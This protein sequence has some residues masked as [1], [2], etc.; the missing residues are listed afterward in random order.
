MGQP[1]SGIVQ[2]NLAGPQMMQSG[3][4]IHNGYSKNYFVEGLGC[5]ERYLDIEDVIGAVIKF[6]PIENK[7]MAGGKISKLVNLEL[8]DLENN[9]LPVSR[10]DQYAEQFDTFLN[11]NQDDR[12]IVIILQFGKFKPF[13]GRTQVSNAYNVTMLF[14]NSE[15]DEITSFKKRLHTY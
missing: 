5:D 2:Q 3:I 8:E 13:K 10:W 4:R 12:N 15:I 9:Y 6:H 1:V 11:D 14:I 7:E